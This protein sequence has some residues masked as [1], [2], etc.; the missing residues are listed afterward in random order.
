MGTP[1]AVMLDSSDGA[2]EAVLTALARKSGL[3]APP[4]LSSN[5][6]SSASCS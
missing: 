2:F 4:T 3:Y 6:A 1:D 5:A